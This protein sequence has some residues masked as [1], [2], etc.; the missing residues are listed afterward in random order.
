MSVR[1]M[2][3]GDDQAVAQLMH[4][5]WP[6]EEPDFSDQVFFVWDDGEIGGFVAVS[7]RPWAEGCTNAP[8]PFIEGWYVSP[9]LR[10]RGV[11]RALLA[12]AEAWAVQQ[13]FSEIGSDVEVDN[14][15]SL[16]AH[17]ALGYTPTLRV[18]YFRKIL[19][20]D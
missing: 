20:R 14:T 19:E 13:G 2:R 8:V 9:A 15:P 10:R 18:Q 12:A 16:E 3:P 11:G 5:L 1:P 7:I 17:A 6:G 4:S